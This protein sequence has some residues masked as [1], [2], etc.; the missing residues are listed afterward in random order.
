MVAAEIHDATYDTNVSRPIMM[1]CNE[2]TWGFYITQDHTCDQHVA[3]VH[4]IPQ[5]SISHISPGMIPAG[6]ML[7]ADENA[8]EACKS[9]STSPAC[10]ISF[11]HFHANIPGFRQCYHSCSISVWKRALTSASVEPISCCDSCRL[12]MSNYMLQHDRNTYARC[13]IQAAVWECCA[14]VCCSWV[15]V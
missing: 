9:V 13:Y 14:I 4:T 12:I 6:F 7:P 3:H 1:L 15:D 2:A 8:C 5:L 10:C 11:I